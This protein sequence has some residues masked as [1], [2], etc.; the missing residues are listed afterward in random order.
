MEGL[1]RVIVAVAG[2]VDRVWQRG[3]RVIGIGRRSGEVRLSSTVVTRTPGRRAEQD[4]FVIDEDDGEEL[5]DRGRPEN[6]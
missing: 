2:K 3:L 6:R 5:E 4:T 1:N